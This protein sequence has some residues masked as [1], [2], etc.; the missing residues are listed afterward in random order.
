MMVVCV[1]LVSTLL[2]TSILYVYF[3]TSLRDE[4]HIELTLQGESLREIIRTFI[5]HQQERVDLILNNSKLPLVLDA[6]D[7]G[8]LIT[9]GALTDAREVVQHL[10]DSTPEFGRIQIANM[11]GEVVIATGENRESIPNIGDSHL[12]KQGLNELYLEYGATVDD[13]RM[14]HVSTPVQTLRGETVGVLVVDFRTDSLEASIGALR[15]PHESSRVRIATTNPEGDIVYVHGSIEEPQ[16][17]L[18]SFVDEPIE[19]ALKGRTGFIDDW[20]DDRGNR[21]LSAHMPIGFRDWVLATQVDAA[22]AY[23]PINRTFFV[24]LLTGIGFA[25]LAVL[26]ATSGVNFLLRSIQRLVDATGQ[27]AQ[28]NYTVRVEE[29]TS[30][31]VGLLSRSFNRMAKQIEEN[32][33]TLE[34]KVSDRTAQL[35]TSRDRLSMVVR[36][37]ESQTDLMQ[38]DLRRAETIQQSLLPRAV[39][40]LEKYSIAGAYI[41]GRNV[42]GDLFNV[43]QIDDQHF[44]FFV[45][46]AAG[47]GAAAALLSVLFKLRVE[48][49]DDP[50]EFLSPRKLLQRVNESIVEDVSAPGVFVTTCFCTL[51][52]ST[53]QLVVVSAGHPPLLIVRADGEMHLIPHTGPALG[54]RHGV[55]FSEI[56]TSLG[57]GDS[58]LLYTDGIFDVGSEDTPTMEQLATV[59]GS[60][61]SNKQK[62]KRLLEISKGDPDQKDKDDITY[63]LLQAREEPNYLPTNLNFEKNG[64]ESNSEGTKKHYQIGYYE[65]EHETILYLAHRITWQYGQVFFDAATS[66]IEEQRPLIVELAGCTY[67]DS[68]MLGTLHEVVERAQKLGVPVSIQNVLDEIERSFVELGL[69]SVLDVIALE[70]QKV[71]DPSEATV[72]ESPHDIDHELRILKAHEELASLNE[73]NEEEFSYVVEELQEELQQRQNL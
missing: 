57:Q 71:P 42:G 20:V 1:I 48:L 22:D 34:Q 61:E 35:E 26:L 39:P 68:A 3:R 52:T 45:A 14:S 4:I 56:H 47:H 36:T 17:S 32:T 53:D 30:D 40:E 6:M 51:D 73:S 50:S 44:A 65:S 70:P 23:S 27:L 31:E 38:R 58:M 7:K 19:R 10:T 49:P 18:V 54:L 69:N 25:T 62:L 28:G 55:E 67:L 11:Q 60:V 43:V 66:V 12:F 21:V 15:R 63:L 64:V 5:S 33:R 46:D 8:V 9:A 13:N 59:V 41:P 72:I 2:L 37:L 29:Q 24:V 16:S